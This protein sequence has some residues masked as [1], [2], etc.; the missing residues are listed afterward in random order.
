MRIVYDASVRTKPTAPSL[1]EHLNVGSPL[2]NQLSK[3]IVHGRF[4]PVAIAG[5]IK[6]AFLHVQV[7]KED[8]DALQFH[9]VN[10]ENPKEILV[11]RFT[12]LLFGLGLSPFL[13]GGVIQQHLNAHRE[14]DP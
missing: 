14:G 12:H 2:Q 11:L 4:H 7:Q 10:K 9:W 13:F 5:D 6:K 1:N 8:R 3:V